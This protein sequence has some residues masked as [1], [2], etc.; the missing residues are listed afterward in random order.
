MKIVSLTL[1]LLLAALQSSFG[2]N[3]PA[4]AQENPATVSLLPNGDYMGIQKMESP[5]PQDK[6]T[7]WFYENTLLIRNGEA[8]LDMVP[9]SI[10]H[11]IKEYSASDGGFMTYRGHFFQKSSQLFVSLRLFKS[12]YIGF[13]VGGCEPYSRIYSSPV[14]LVTDKIEIQG[15]LFEPR[16]LDK[17]VLERLQ[18]ELSKE[19]MEYT[20]EHPYN[21]K[22]RSVP[23]Q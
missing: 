19:P 17:K 1:V 3:H 6:K 14:K 21:Q 9:F 18:L 10:K 2:Q 13:P 22:Y 20:G 12:D 15:V 16:Q 23:C 11:K 8:I 5:T 4:A 7:K